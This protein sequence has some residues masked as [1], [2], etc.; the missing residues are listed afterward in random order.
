MT[1]TDGRVTTWI[2]V[3]AVDVITPDRGV[4]ARIGE[5]QVALFVLS[6]GEVYALDNR[7]PFSG[8]NVLCNGIVGD[9]DG[10]PTVASPVYKQR[11]ALTTGECLDNPEV[12]VGRWDAHADSGRVYVRA[13]R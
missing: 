2:D 1:V 4:A 10:V 8:A 13:P 11:F 6:S 5:A 9:H 3:C 12:S 7:D